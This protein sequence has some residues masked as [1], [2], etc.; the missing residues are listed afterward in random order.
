MSTGYYTLGESVLTRS[1]E[2]I[3]DEGHYCVNGIKFPCPQGTISHHCFPREMYDSLI[4][5]WFVYYKSICFY[6]DF[7]HDDQKAYKFI[8]FFYL[9]ELVLQPYY[10]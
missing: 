4:I 5:Q 10:T 7:G 3:C 1:A 2:R 6:I 8:C 9:R